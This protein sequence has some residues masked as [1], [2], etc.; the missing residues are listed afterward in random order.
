MTHGG[1]RRRTSRWSESGF[2]LMIATVALVITGLIV[3]PGPTPAA[4][5]GGPKVSVG[6][7]TIVEGD[8]GRNVV[9]VP[10]TL[11]EQ[12]TAPVTLTW[13]VT[14]GTATRAKNEGPGV[15]V[16]DPGTTRTLSI[17]AGRLRA[18]L[19]LEVLGDATPESAETIVVTVQSVSGG[20]GAVTLADATGTVTIIDDDPVSAP[21]VSVGS[22]TV[23]EG[24]SPSARSNV[25]LA[26]DIPMTLTIS[27]VGTPS[28]RHSLTPGRTSTTLG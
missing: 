18:G 22:A 9:R 12:Q 27:P 8:N 1:A 20:N 6:D 23:V 5:S 28:T 13:A 4:A 7:V 19:S 25:N 16:K 15:D 17:P 14:G 24:D 2:G 11:S 21:A 3:V 26:V 10:V